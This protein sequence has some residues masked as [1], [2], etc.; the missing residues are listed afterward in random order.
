MR[1]A[2]LKSGGIMSS[3]TNKQS[4]RKY[5]LDKREALS[6]QTQMDASHQLIQ[7][8]LKHRVFKALNKE[9]IV[10]AYYAA[11]GEMSPLPLL[12]R[13]VQHQ[14]KTALP[15]I[16]EKNQPLAFA[17]W[18]PET[19]MMAGHIFAHIAEPHHNPDERCLPSVVMVPLLAVDAQ[20]HRLGFG[21]GYYDRTLAWL[22]EK[23]SDLV[24]I[25]IGYGWQ[26]Q[27][28][29]LPIEA[30]DIPLDY[31]LCEEGMSAF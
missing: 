5:Y 6:V 19:E 3:I 25:G 30:H 22:K 18:H 15:I 31:F 7:H 11:S 12:E 10:A 23:N 27:D 16:V 14:I 1:K 21:G 9:S 13:L 4:L 2:N 26:K 8:F 29:P 20:G 17:P 28:P 24:I